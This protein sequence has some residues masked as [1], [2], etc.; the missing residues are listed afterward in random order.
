MISDSP[1]TFHTVDIAD[2]KRVILRDLDPL[3][4]RIFQTLDPTTAEGSEFAAR[5]PGAFRKQNVADFVGTDFR[6]TQLCLQRIRLVCLAHGFT[7]EA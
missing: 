1:H 6:N 2:L 3:S 4:R 7:P 5:Y